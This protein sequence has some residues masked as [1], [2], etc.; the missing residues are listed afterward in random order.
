MAS[1]YYNYQ[2]YSNVRH[3]SHQLVSKKSPLLMLMVPVPN[4]C[5]PTD[6][7]SGSFLLFLG[8]NIDWVSFTSDCS[9]SNGG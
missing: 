4:V 2:N 1:N 7:D 6:F 9:M 3:G 5:V 8:F